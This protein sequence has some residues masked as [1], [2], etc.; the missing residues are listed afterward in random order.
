[1]IPQEEPAEEEEEKEK[2][3]SP[4]TKDAEMTTV[5]FDAPAESSED[6]EYSEDEDSD[7]EFFS[8][9]KDFMLVD[10]DC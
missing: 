7:G 5:A 10:K 3:K 4:P 9:F 1:V 2:P 8:E 6:L